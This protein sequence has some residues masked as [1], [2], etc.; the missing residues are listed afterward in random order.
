MLPKPAACIHLTLVEVGFS[1]LC[2]VVTLLLILRT[3]IS[4]ACGLHP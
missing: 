4:L 1:L 3:E 2:D